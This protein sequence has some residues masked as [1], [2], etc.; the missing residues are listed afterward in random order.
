MTASSS[1]KGA[2]I[3]PEE[4]EHAK[5]RGVHLW[6]SARLRH[7]GRRLPHHRHP[8]RSTALT[9]CMRMAISDAGLNP[10]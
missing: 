8:P 1:A 9:S 2:M 10:S 3:V 6:R 7:N 4:L 5:K